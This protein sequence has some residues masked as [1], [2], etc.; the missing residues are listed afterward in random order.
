MTSF[1][2]GNRGP[3]R[4]FLRSTAIELVDLLHMGNAARAARHLMLRRMRR[5]R[6]SA[7]ARML[8]FWR[9]L[10]PADR[11]TE[12]CR[13]AIQVLRSRMPGEEFSHYLEFGV[14]RGTSL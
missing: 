4:N 1:R 14:S 11:F 10:V 6:K 12:C 13:N 7:H 2:R 9:P 5:M 8:W 3:R